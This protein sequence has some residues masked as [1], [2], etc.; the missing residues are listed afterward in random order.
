MNSRIWPTSEPRG[1]RPLA[2]IALRLHP[3]PAKMDS[4]QLKAM[5]CECEKTCFSTLNHILAF[6]YDDAR[7]IRWL[8]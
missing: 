5:K 2:P 4:R 1:P 7:V 6:C 8:F 3:L